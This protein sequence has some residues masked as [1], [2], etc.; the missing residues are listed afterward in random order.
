MPGRSVDFRT[1][2]CSS[3]TQNE[4]TTYIHTNLIYF[5]KIKYLLYIFIFV[6]FILDVNIRYL[7][8]IEASE[9]N[10]TDVE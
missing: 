9:G 3:F 5:T 6:V 10:M 2:F 7:T 4:D 8:K 1:K